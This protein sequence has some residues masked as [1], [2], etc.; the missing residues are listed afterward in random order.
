MPKG[1]FETFCD[2]LDALIDRWA[3][4]PED[5]RLSRAEILGALEH[6][7]F[8]INMETAIHEIDDDD[9]CTLKE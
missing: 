9:T 4:K 3:D 5:D 8:R 7:K 2:E 1:P 6:K